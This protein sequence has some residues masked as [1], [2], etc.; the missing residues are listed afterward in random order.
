M[1]GDTFF[2][3]IGSCGNCG[4]STDGARHCVLCYCVSYCDDVCEEAHLFDH[5]VACNSQFH[6]GVN[7]VTDV[8]LRLRI[9]GRLWV[10]THTSDIVDVVLA[11]YMRV[12][13]RMENSTRDE[14][15]RLVRAA[16][17][18]QF[19]RMSLFELAR[20]P[21]HVDPR[22][23]YVQYERTNGKLIPAET[24]GQITGRRTA[25]ILHSIEDRER[26]DPDGAAIV[27]HV[28]VY[29]DDWRNSVEFT[30]LLPVPDVSG[31][32]DRIVTRDV[33]DLDARL[34]RRGDETFRFWTKAFIVN[35]AQGLIDEYVVAFALC[36]FSGWKNIIVVAQQMS[37]RPRISKKRKGAAVAALD[38]TPPRFFRAVPAPH[39][40]QSA[41]VPR[42]TIY[43]SDG[44]T[45]VGHH[46]E[47]STIYNTE[48]SSDVPRRNAISTTASSSANL[49]AEEIPD[50]SQ[51]EHYSLPPSNPPTSP[52]RK[53]R[54]RQAHRWLV[55]TLPKLLKPYLRLI[56]QTNSF[57][58]DPHP[59]VLPCTCTVQSRLLEVAIVRFG[60]IERVE[61]DVCSC[62]SAPELLV[63]QGCFPCAPV[64]PTLAVDMRVLEFVSKL[65][66]R[67]PPNH[68]A[69]CD[70]LDDFL[71]DQGY[72][73]K[74]ED[75]LRRRFSNAL[76]WYNSLKHQVEM[77]VDNLIQTARDDS[78]SYHN[79][80]GVSHE[81]PSPLISNA[82]SH[83]NPSDDSEEDSEPRKK[84]RPTLPTPN[85]LQRPSYYLR[86]RCP[87][88]FGSSVQYSE[89]FGAI[90]CV[91]ACFTQKHNKQVPDHPTS[92]PKSVFIPEDIVKEMEARVELIRPP[93]SHPKPQ[94]PGTDD[95]VPD[96]YEGPLKVPIS[97]LDGCQDSFTAADER[98]EKASTQFF[99]CTGLMGL[100]CRHDRVLWLV[101]MK[102]AGE[103]QH[104]VLVL[105]EMLFKHL[106]DTF[107]IGLLTSYLGFLS[108][109]RCFMPSDTV[110]HAKWY[111]TP[112]NVPD[113]DF[114]MERDASV[115]GI[116]SYHVRIYTLDMQIR[117]FDRQAL[118]CLGQW[119]ERKWLSCHERRR[120]AVNHLNEAGYQEQF[121]RTEWEA[122]VAYQTKPLP[123]RSKRSGKRAVEEVVH[124]REAVDQIKE[125]IMRLE[126]LLL[127]ISLSVPVRIDIKAD[128]EVKEV[129]LRDAQRKLRICE[130][131]LGVEEQQEVSNL[132]NN[133][134]INARMNA[135]AVK[136][137]LVERLR[138]R[139]F[140]RD[141][142]ERSYRKHSTNERKVDQHLEDAV[143]KRDPSIQR[144]AK[145]FNELVANMEKLIRLGKAPPN[146]VAPVAIDLKKLFKLDVDDAI[147]HD[148]GLD[149][150]F[151][152]SPPPWLSDDNVRSA[153][154]ALL[155][156]ERCDEELARLQIER[157][158][159]QEWFAEEW[160]VI[161]HAQSACTDSSI[162]FQF[163]ILRN[164]F[165]AILYEWRRSMRVLQASPGTSSWGPLPTEIQSFNSVLRRDHIKESVSTCPSSDDEDDEGVDSG[166]DAIDPT[167]VELLDH[168]DLV[169]SD[170]DNDAF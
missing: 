139:K 19:W 134:Y 28:T 25:D 162:L 48:V 97:I 54:H 1:P 88:C 128:L 66:L 168:I 93:R 68:T 6:A 117:H 105:L 20:P 103:K 122:Q 107:T 18:S 90:V 13:S 147:W 5:R 123:A 102:S 30:T 85:S 47:T 24:L 155:E 89:G 137:R 26:L 163:H 114:L 141:R 106:P 64:S 152:H 22:G 17:R 142:L 41:T 65:F 101:N 58:L 15:V 151:P 164:E 38:A 67:M 62:R 45:L 12:N 144:L 82:P 154:Q 29:T 111:I 42:P 119:M 94:P 46:R 71:H 140:E 60:M 84:T 8:N 146:A 44:Q 69:W 124:L 169:E 113:L 49:V 120:L 32:Q 72:H 160:A 143:T 159:I 79:E 61:L 158:S 87:A 53:K 11:S 130:A 127:D 108:P 86:S 10:A 75:P 135:M 133:P 55:E 37:S 4:R 83:T 2:S 92:Y 116:P 16:S 52:H 153:I 161:G 3:N 23:C 125:R 167:L 100:L 99:D 14:F 81:T 115:S 118:L 50:S 157:D 132:L 7:L 165:L 74:G 95:D 104:Y 109:F 148:F 131:N 73:L 80:D 76:Q 96:G 21:H 31:L 126:N 33:R 51:Y 70:T 166:S 149:D 150:D 112:G 170:S 43:L 98:R 34:A 110:G 129:Q 156:K 36:L 57:H 91:D 27:I 121:L 138:Q 35:A 56:E 9:A 145:Q 39:H 63:A 136:T 78:C 59:C 40:R 77:F